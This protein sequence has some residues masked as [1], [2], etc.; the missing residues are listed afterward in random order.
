MTIHMLQT[1]TRADNSDTISIG[2]KETEHCDWPVVSKWF[3]DS[4]S[5]VAGVKVYLGI[6]M[7]SEMTGNPSCERY[8]LLSTQ[9]FQIYAKVDRWF[10]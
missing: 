2:I 6:W 8:S 9:I 5:M 1:K 10:I 7:A 3:L 4:V